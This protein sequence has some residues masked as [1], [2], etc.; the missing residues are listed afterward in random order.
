MA[1]RT[2]A[3]FYRRGVPNSYHNFA[4]VLQT[5]NT[6]VVPIHKYLQNYKFYNR[7]VI[8]KNVRQA[9]YPWSN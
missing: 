5:N 6:V 8:N 2:S 4:Y 3:I 9:L 1:I 7:N